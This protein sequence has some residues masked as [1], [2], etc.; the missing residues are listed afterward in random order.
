VGTQSAAST[1][2]G[3]TLPDPKDKAPLLRTYRQAIELIGDGRL[4]ESAVLL[5]QILDQDPNMTDVW[6]QYATV[7]GRLNRFEAAFEAYTRVIKL[8]PEEPN[9]ALGAAS[10]LLALNRL[11]AA[12]MHAEL[13]LK[14]AP[15]QAH[16]ALALIEVARKRDAEAIRQ[17]TL[18]AEAD[19]GLPMPAFIRGTIAFNKGQ[20][21]EAIALLQEARKGY[22]GRSA[23]PRDL[24][25]MIGDALARL[26]RY[27]EAEPY[28][29]EE[30][31][32][33]PQH[34]RARAGLAMLYQSMGRAADAERVLD[35][36]VRA[37][38]TRDGF[39]TA[40]NLWRMSG[41]PDRAAAVEQRL[42]RGQRH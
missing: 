42:P 13:A 9:G 40:A 15:S 19:P 16:Q 11:D 27:Q 30:V 35:E 20:Y 21:P 38:P 41:R 39:E 8:R 25:Y 29:K 7:L 17:A 3:A 2:S 26:D 12:R 18:A 5:R 32:L 24:Y 4:E 37:V 14:T 22:A 36:L 28:L 6:S 34:V 31:R 33:Y 1:T 23:Q 10:M